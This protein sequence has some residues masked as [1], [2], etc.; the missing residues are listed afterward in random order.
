MF[1][2]EVLDLTCLQFELR[3]ESSLKLWDMNSS[4]AHSDRI[5]TVFKGLKRNV[6]I[7]FRLSILINKLISILLDDEI[8]FIWVVRV[9]QENPHAFSVIIVD[10]NQEGSWRLWIHRC[11]TVK[12]HRPLCQ[13]SISRLMVFEL[14]VIL[15]DLQTKVNPGAWLL[16]RVDLDN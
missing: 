4:I 1:D 15:R 5:R 3:T 10:L 8:L 7:L 9:T 13:E 14:L 2:Q 12:Y 16:H 11:V 6:I